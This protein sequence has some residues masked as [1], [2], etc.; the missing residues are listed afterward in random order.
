MPVSRNPPCASPRWHARGAA[1]RQ[2]P[3]EPPHIAEALSAARQHHAKPTHLAVALHAVRRRPRR[4][5]TGRQRL[6]K[7]RL[8]LLPLH[9]RQ[10]RAGYAP[11]RLRVPDGLEQL[12]AAGGDGGLAAGKCL[13]GAAAAARCQPCL[14]RPRGARVLCST[15]FCEAVVAHELAMLSSSRRWCG[16]A[17]KGGGEGKSGCRGSGEIE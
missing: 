2:T 5:R 15:H 17:G 10:L 9:R 7:P 4:P 11:C 8:G 6:L 13:L 12:L 3:A 1:A 14:T 16:K